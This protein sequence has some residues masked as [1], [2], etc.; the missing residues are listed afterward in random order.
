LKKLLME[1]CE[2]PVADAEEDDD[3]VDSSVGVACFS[4]VA[5]VVSSRAVARFFLAGDELTL[6]ASVS[7]VI[8]GG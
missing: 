7:A 6:E 4:S 3:A 5:V 1:R 2:L 8:G